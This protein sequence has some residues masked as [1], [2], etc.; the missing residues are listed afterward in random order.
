M[1]DLPEAPWLNISADFYGPLPT[2]EYLLVIID[3]YSR[4]PIVEIIRS[5]SANTVI[6]VFDKVFSMFGLPRVVKTD[7]GPPFNSEQFSKFADCLGFHHRKITP[8][9][10]QANATAERFMRTLRKAI[11]VSETVNIPWKQ[12]LNTFLR[13]Y[14]STPHST[15][16]ASPA[17]LMLRY[18]M[19]TKVPTLTSTI[20]KNIDH[21][22]RDKDNTAKAK[23]KRNSDA[24]RHAKPRP[25]IP[26]D[27]VLHKQPKHNKLTTPY[28]SKPH[29]VSK[30]KGSM[31]T[32]TR[33]GH[34]ITR[35]S[36]F[37][38]RV[39]PEIQDIPSDPDEDDDGDAVTGASP[40]PQRYPSRTRRQRPPYLRDYV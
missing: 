8:L 26:G 1:S 27:A 35:N 38:K 33:D 36:S 2:G 21:T 18:K 20:E 23:M 5:T 30:V 22:I 17:D 29:T 37:F 10:P 19:H 40:R 28:N 12:T 6:P 13:E 14:R 9:W 11:R 3:E 16:G 24:R 31:V 4:Y 7:N 34:S 15:T 25:L 32:A 39:N